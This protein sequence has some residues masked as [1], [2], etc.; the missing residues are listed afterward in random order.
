MLGRTDNQALDR[1]E[2][3]VA[4]GMADPAAAVANMA[5]IYQTL[6][7]F[8]ERLTRPR[9]P[10]R[11]YVVPFVGAVT[12]SSTA[13]T[14]IADTP[15][16]WPKKCR[17]VGFKGIV[18]EGLTL[19]SH[20][21]IRVKDQNGYSFFSNGTSDAF[22]SLAQLQ[23]NAYDQ[24]GWFPFLETLV[25]PGE[26]WQIAASSGDSLPGSGSTNYTPEVIFL[27]DELE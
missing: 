9:V 4:A 18:R 24:G 15:L 22:V 6:G 14:G 5:E 12:V 25:K 11:L 19:S 2:R 16:Q 23:G 7:P 17:V 20:V 13:I 8:K 26:Q 27:V 10:Q 1:I 3:L 21:T